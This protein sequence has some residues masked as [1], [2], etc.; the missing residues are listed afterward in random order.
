MS[1]SKEFD[2]SAFMYIWLVSYSSPSGGTE[3]VAYSAKED[4]VKFMSTVEN[5]SLKQIELK[6]KFIPLLPPKKKR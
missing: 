5:A 6:T 2:S 3:F 1:G 4:A